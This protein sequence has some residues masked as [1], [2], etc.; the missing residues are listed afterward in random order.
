MASNIEETRI[1]EV[2]LLR[3]KD[4]YCGIVIVCRI[5][6]P[7]AMREE[8]WKMED[9]YNAWRLLIRDPN[10]FFSPDPFPLTLALDRV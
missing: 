4:D 5:G 8:G 2:L 3:G 10:G 9:M 6:C 7:K 1:L